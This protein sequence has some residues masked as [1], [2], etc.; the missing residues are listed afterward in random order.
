MSTAVMAKPVEFI[1][2]FS[3]K[4]LDLAGMT[5]DQLRDGLTRCLAVTAEGLWEAAQYWRELAKI[6]EDMSKWRVG[7]ARYVALIA[8]GRLHALAVNAFLDEP[9]KIKAIEGLPLK[10]QAELARG[11]EV[12]VFDT[13]KKEVQRVP[14]TQL[15]H[16]SLGHVFRHGREVPASEQRIQQQG[17][18]ESADEPNVRTIK[19][20]R[21]DGILQIGNTKTRIESVMGAMAEAAGRQGNIDRNQHAT[22]QGRTIIAQVTDD[23]A[24]RITAT[25]K[26]SGLPLAEWARR[27]LLV[28]LV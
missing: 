16:Q 7:A 13:A 4:E 26:A 24:D 27:R 19:V 14:F 12:E 17:K 22:A 9:S 21:Q 1:D 11:A 25:A 20:N 23:E 18:K 5:R 2:E 3:G 10:R 28:G 6:G 15:P 8:T